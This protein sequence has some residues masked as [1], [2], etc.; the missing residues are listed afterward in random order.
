[1]MASNST[2]EWLLKE[3]NSFFVLFPL[4]YRIT[5]LYMSS[6]A[7]WLFIKGLLIKIKEFT[8]ISLELAL[9]RELNLSPSLP[10]GSINEELTDFDQCSVWIG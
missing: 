9:H 4:L 8:I 1:M 5:R 10:T 3:Q 7:I 2:V 6:V